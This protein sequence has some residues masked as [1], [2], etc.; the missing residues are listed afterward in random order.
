MSKATYFDDDWINLELYPSFT[1][2]RKLPDKRKELCTVC[3]KTFALSNMGIVAVKSHEKSAKHA[4]KIVSSSQ[5]TVLNY[6]KGSTVVGGQMESLVPKA[7]CLKQ[8]LT[9]FPQ[10]LAMFLVPKLIH[11]L[12]KEILHNL[13]YSGLCT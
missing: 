3:Q 10:L 12:F 2:L 11:F 13:K 4:K 9:K 6:F 5:P 1:W 8:Q 7:L